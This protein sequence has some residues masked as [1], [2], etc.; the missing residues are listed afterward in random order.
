[1]RLSGRHYT[2]PIE[3]SYQRETDRNPSS[4]DHWERRQH[5]STGGPYRYGNSRKLCTPDNANI[6]EHDRQPN[7]KVLGKPQQ[8]EATNFT[9]IKP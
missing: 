7:G 3:R 6:T 1:M 2:E 8:S 5:R 4:A 9:N